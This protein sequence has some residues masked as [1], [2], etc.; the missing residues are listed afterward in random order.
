MTTNTDKK[1]SGLQKT[2]VAF[3][4]GEFNICSIKP[5]YFRN[6]IAEEFNDLRQPQLETPLPLER[7]LSSVIYLD[8]TE[9]PC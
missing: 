4:T 9:P 5:A 6:I 8:N 3:Y 2:G 1:V 7:I